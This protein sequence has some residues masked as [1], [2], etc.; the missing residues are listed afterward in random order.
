MNVEYRN[1]EFD[2]NALKWVNFWSKFY[3][4]TAYRNI[5]AG[6]LQLCY[7]VMVNTLYTIVLEV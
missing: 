4:I 2:T 5:F 6:I 7:N 1:G 3:N